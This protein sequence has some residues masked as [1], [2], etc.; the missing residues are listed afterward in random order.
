MRALWSSGATRRVFR[1]H[2][3]MPY[4][5][6]HAQ[7]TVHEQQGDASWKMTDVCATARSRTGS[8]KGRAGRRPPVREYP[9]TGRQA[10][11]GQGMR[12]L[13]VRGLRPCLL[14]TPGPGVGFPGM[15]RPGAAVHGMCAAAE[16][17]TPP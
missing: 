12:G 6:E 3:D 14:H 15:G 13:L 4:A 16:A 11:A 10:E 7:A 17:V 1:V 5:H 2:E 9:V 8:G